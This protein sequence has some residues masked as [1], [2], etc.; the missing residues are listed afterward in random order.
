MV[1]QTLPVLFT[2]K[3]KQTSLR[4]GRKKTVLSQA[5]EKFEGFRTF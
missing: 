3:S 5:K 4:Q 2:K 1:G